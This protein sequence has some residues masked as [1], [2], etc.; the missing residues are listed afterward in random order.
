MVLLNDWNNL[1]KDEKLQCGCMKKESPHAPSETKESIK[2]HGSP[3]Q[4]RQ[5][6]KRNQSYLQ[7]TALS[8]LSS[9]IP[10]S[11]I[12]LWQQYSSFLQSLIEP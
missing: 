8:S 1:T 5:L 7:P 12:Q 10:S 3:I 2:I 9:R 11:S 6:P 4:I